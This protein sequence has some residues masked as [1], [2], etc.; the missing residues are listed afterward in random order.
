MSE[1]T[2][3]AVVGSINA[4][5]TVFSSP[6]PRPGETVTGESFSMGLGGKGANQALAAARAG[7]PTYMIGAV[8]DD[9]FADLTL[10][11][12]RSAGV[13]VSKVATL[14]GPTGIAHV[15][16][17]THSGQNDIV[18][19]PHANARLVADDAAAALRA[20]ADVVSV[21]LI[22]LEIPI[23][24]VARVSEVCRE[25]GLTLLLDPAPAQRLPD[26]SWAGVSVAKPNESE[27]AQVTGLPVTDHATAVAAG[28]WL[29]DRGV[30]IAVITRGSAG[31]TVVE[32]ERVTELEPFAVRAVDTTAAGDAFSGALGAGLA[33]GLPF[34][35]AAR[36]AM[37]A[38]A[39]AVTVRGASS[40]LPTADAI[41]AFLAAQPAPR[42]QP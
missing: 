14:E 27:A 28:R 24:V 30:T 18:V 3:V 38:A 12:L 17:N 15:R 42:P 10:S 13:D 2:G 33:A 36:R 32:A 20:L 22:Q 40:S 23:P 5:L 4:D 41:D 16:V 6:L 34:P 39:L 37:A 25:L 8:G 21:V 19:V 29:V 7:V 26:A 31:A 1:R 9:A 11:T 35:A